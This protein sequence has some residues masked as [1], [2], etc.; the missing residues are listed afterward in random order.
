MNQVLLK[1]AGHK[2]CEGNAHRSSCCNA[3]IITAL[4]FLAYLITKQTHGNLKMTFTTCHK[5]KKLII[6]ASG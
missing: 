5:K 1:W 4:Q 6:D 2:S 3:A